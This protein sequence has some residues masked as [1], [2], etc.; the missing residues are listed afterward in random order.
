MNTPYSIYRMTQGSG[1]YCLYDFNLY[2]AT[3]LVMICV[4]LMHDSDCM[5]IPAK[6]DNSVNE[7]LKK[8]MHN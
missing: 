3:S 6:S 5:I 7:N 2:M 1:V 4:M 8:S